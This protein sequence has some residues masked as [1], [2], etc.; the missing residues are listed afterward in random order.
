[1][2]LRFS[3]AQW[4][5]WAPGLTD[6]AAWRAWLAAPVALPVEGT[7]ALAEMPA[8]MRRRVDR[9]GRVALQ[10]AY[11]GLG[12]TRECPIV[13]ASRYGSIGRSIELLQQLAAEDTVSPTGF[14]MSVHN[15]IAAQFSIARQD[16]GNYTA[17]AAG[18]ETVEAAFTEAIGLL[19]DG[20]SSVLVVFYDEPLPE[21]LRGPI[22]MLDFARAWACRIEPATHGGISVSSRAA[23]AAAASVLPADLAVL[24]FLVSDEPELLRVATPRA[25]H[26]CRHA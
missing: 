19:A 5:A 16:A 26:W 15:A 6:A 25:W 11:W 9:L 17:V 2:T 7:P 8:M 18:D 3:I 10:A 14:S 12:D 22:G 21:A 23:G 13:F 20:A 24:R 1:M 4:A